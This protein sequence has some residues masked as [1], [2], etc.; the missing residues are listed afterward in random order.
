M[1]WVTA[2]PLRPFRTGAGGQS[3]SRRAPGRWFFISSVVVVPGHDSN[4]EPFGP[5]LRF[6]RAPTDFGVRATQVLRSLRVPREALRPFPLHSCMYFRLQVSPLR[7]RR[8]LDLL[9][10]RPRTVLLLH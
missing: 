6:F 8:V 5:E 4:D 1:S 7:P 2:P 3:S 9:L 10:L